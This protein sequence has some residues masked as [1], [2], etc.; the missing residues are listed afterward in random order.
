MRSPG[1]QIVPRIRGPLPLDSAMKILSHRRLLY[2]SSI[3]VTMFVIALVAPTAS[4][5]AEIR[6]LTSRAMS[7][8]LTELGDAFQ[9]A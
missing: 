2:L 9:R 8:V 5:A 1:T 7:H 6:V 4:V 3:P